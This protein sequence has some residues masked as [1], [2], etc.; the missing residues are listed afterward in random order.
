M[1]SRVIQPR[2]S[3][4][5]AT[6]ARLARSPLVIQAATFAGANTLTTAIG[7]ISTILLARNLSTSQYGSYSFANSALAFGAMFF[8]F[9]LFLPAAR[10]LARGD[11]PHKEIVAATTVAFLPVGVGLAACMLVLSFRVDEWF[12]VEAGAALRLAAPLML[13]YPYDFVAFQLAQGL[14]R[15]NLHSITR[16]LARA[17]AVGM[18][19]L[20][21]ITGHDLTVGSA[22]VIESAAL[23][24]AWTSFTIRLRPVYRDVGLRV[25]SFLQGA[26]KYGFQVYIG[27]VLSS[28]TYNMDT[29]MLAALTDARSVGFYALAGTIAYL[30][31]LPGAGMAAALFSR[32]ANEHR[33]RRSWLAAAWLLGFAAAGP[34]CVLVGWFVRLAV[35]PE[36]LPV[37]GLLPPLALA[38]V[39]RSVTTVYNTYL[40]AHA[41]GTELSNAALL[42]TGGNLIL[43]ACLIPPFGAVGAAWASLLALLVNLVVHVAFYRR[44]ERAYEQAAPIP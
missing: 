9:G 28:G 19:V 20:L 26:H 33:V 13:V 16:V 15:I 34:A 27:R 43:N 38:Q 21:M 2:R 41:R 14:D 5:V 40:T 24:L 12:H 1:G 31:G 6:L 7:G 22:L 11:T 10:Q 8:E 25:R 3:P 32:M 18:L 42:L 39:V 35:G 30:V 4:G 17:G 29:L 37:V 23:L 44:V 36:Y